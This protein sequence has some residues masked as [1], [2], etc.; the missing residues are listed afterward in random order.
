[1]AILRNSYVALL[2]T[3]PGSDDADSGPIRLVPTDGDPTEDSAQRIFGFVFAEQ[4]GAGTVQAEVL[5]SFGDG[6]W[7]IFGRRTLNAD[8]QHFMGFEDI[9]A[10]PPYVRCRVTAAPPEGSEVKPNFVVAFRFASNAPF[11]GEPANVP[12]IL[13]RV[14]TDNVFPNDNE[15]NNNPPP[16]GG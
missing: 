6:L 3:T 10:I 13:E 14:A 2:R 5:A 15:G 11:R 9:G 8:G 7:A 16:E 4:Q 1:M 12:V